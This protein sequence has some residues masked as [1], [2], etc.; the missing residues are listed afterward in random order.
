MQA[1]MRK[2]GGSASFVIR[3]RETRLLSNQMEKPMQSYWKGNEY[4]NADAGEGIER[5]GGKRFE[6]ILSTQLKLIIVLG[7]LCFI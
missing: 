4:E 2:E 1:R 3:L 7:L 5:G 6:A